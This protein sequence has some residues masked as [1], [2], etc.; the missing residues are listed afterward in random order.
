MTTTSRLNRASGLPDSENCCQ[1]NLAGI[2]IG[3]IL[4]SADIEQIHKLC[5]LSRERKRNVMVRSQSVECLTW[6]AERQLPMDNPLQQ[7]I[8]LIALIAR[9]VLHASGLWYSVAPGDGLW[10]Q[11]AHVSSSMKVPSAPLHSC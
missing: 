3:L 6:R 1:L 4:N 5:E 11:L 7:L 10:M 2:S 8:Q 9:P